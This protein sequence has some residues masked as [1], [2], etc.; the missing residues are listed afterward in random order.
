MAKLAE[1]RLLYTGPLCKALCVD[2]PEISDVLSQPTR[3]RLFSLVGELKRPVPTEELAE[4]VGLHVNGVRRHLERLAKAGLVE[5]RKSSRGRGRP[6]D[7]WTVA[8][9]ASPGGERPRAYADLARWL[10][11]AI[12][13]DPG[14]LR[15]IERTGREIGR[16]V[17]PAAIDGTAQDFV[18]V[19]A[20]LGFQPDLSIDRDGVTRCRL[21][22]CP[23]RDSVTE[24][25]EVIC[26]LHRGMTAGILD[27]IA[28]EARLEA[29]Q[30]HDPGRAGCL[31]EV[32]G[33]GWSGEEGVDEEA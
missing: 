6:R 7:E 18:G 16:E 25:P 32:V 17:A 12:P 11:R 28:P 4:R 26:T 15:E 9:S 14:R 10:A 29:F 27:E 5:R 8:A 24:N 3:A 22:N 31:V 33:A 20:A 30:P 2:P 13:A 23:Y 19:L 1:R 21:C